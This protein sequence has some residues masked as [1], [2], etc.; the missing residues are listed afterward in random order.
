MGVLCLN[1]ALDTFDGSQICP[2]EKSNK[3]E[4]SQQP[5]MPPSDRLES[6]D[7]TVAWKTFLGTWVGQDGGVARENFS[8]KQA[9]F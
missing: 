9:E 4:F 2:Q 7:K 6:S 8:P 5:F 3:L 1:Q